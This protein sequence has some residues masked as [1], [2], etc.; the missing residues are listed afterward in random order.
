M[1][2][3][4]VGCHVS[5]APLVPIVLGITGH[6]NPRP[7]VIP[8]LERKLAAVLTAIDRAAPFSPIV[9]LSPLAA[10]CDQLAARIAVNFR[11][12]RHDVG[13]RVELV[14][15]LP[16]PLA[17]YRNDFADDPAALAEF[18]R[19]RAC[20]SYEVQLPP[21]SVINDQDGAM[22]NELRDAHYRRL[23]LFIAL[24]SQL[25]VA[26][27]DG[28][29]QHKVGGT[30]DI[31]EFC[32][33]GARTISPQAT[34][35]SVSLE[36]RVAREGLRIPFRPTMPLLSPRR[37]TPLVVFAT[38]RTTTGGDAEEAAKYEALNESELAKVCT[39][40]ASHTE[41]LNVALMKTTV[42]YRSR[43][44]GA[45]D[46][47]TWNSLVDRYERLDALASR[48]KSSYLRHA[49]LIATF[50]VLGIC[51]FE[52]FSSF[53]DESMTARYGMLAYLTLLV[54]AYLAWKRSMGG[55]CERHFVESRGLA[56]AMR[57]QLAWLLAGITESVA[58]HYV[59][60]RGNEL[61]LLQSQI[62]AASLEAYSI[63]RDAIQ[64]ATATARDA[65]VAD[66]RD[67]FAA[68]SSGMQRRD[69][70]D[71]RG[72]WLRLWSMRSALMFAVVLSTGVLV[73]VW[74]SGAGPL[75]GFDW[76]VDLGCFIMGSL[77][78]VCVG[79]DYWRDIALDREDLESAK[80]MFPLFEQAMKM[81]DEAQ[82]YGNQ[83][84]VLRALGKEALD[85]SG[86]WISRHRG[87][88]RIP[89]S[90]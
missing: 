51:C 47:E 31:I 1:A 4:A 12:I 70:D 21:I 27:W 44:R 42:L 29:P 30:R 72:Q 88:L 32:R 90:G 17:E 53:G 68:S 23:G 39:Q 49:K 45:V 10:G 64:A 89:D 6:R 62:R 80:R 7:D 26:M 56:E 20:A 25:M 79:I 52:F 60:R 18:E 38:P 81:L 73:H 65:W 78:A 48:F 37:A 28:S 35:E 83:T 66:Q 85:E 76:W 24:Q 82:R 69:R 40:V 3:H 34:S 61:D 63:P 36:A 58:D 54:G 8:E 33:K 55:E 9:F 77:F 75:G 13:M 50:A 71:R 87:R 46:S 84:E 14:V 57:I 59:A 19:L 16:L 11:R 67:Y 86:E 74:V 5:L 22:G 41:L 2:R 15:P 43:F